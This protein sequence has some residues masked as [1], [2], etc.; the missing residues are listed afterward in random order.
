[1][2]SA[3]I[4][5]GNKVLIVAVATLLVWMLQRLLLDHRVVE[6]YPFLDSYLVRIGMAAIAGS[7]AVDF[8]S[9]YDPAPSE[10]I[11]NAGMLIILAWLYRAFHSGNLF[12]KIL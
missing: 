2:M 1:M 10:I 6:K 4:I 5:I 9:M 12:T 8:F 11:L 7:Y 3:I